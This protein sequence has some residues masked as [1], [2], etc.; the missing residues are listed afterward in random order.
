MTQSLDFRKMTKGTRSECRRFLLLALMLLLPMALMAQVESGRVVGTVFDTSGAVISGAAI[1]VKNIGTGVEHHT[2]TDNSGQFTVTQLQPGTY[3]VL[4][5]HEGFKGAE[6]AAFALDV[7]QVIQV[8][9]KLVVGAA[10]QTVEVASVEP[11]IETQTSSL[12]AVVEQ[13]AINDLPLNGRDFIQLT[14]LTPGVNSGPQGAVQGGG[15]PED[16]RGNGS[17]QA[18]GL[19]ATNNN[20]LLDGFDNNEQQIG[21]EI[22]QPPIDAIGEFKM[23]T[24]GFG[25]DIGKG[26]AVINVVLKSGTNKLHGDVYEFLRNSALDAKNYFDS[27]SKP[28]APFRQNQFGGTV[29]GPIRK[30]RT[31]FFVDYQGTRIGQSATSLSF[32]PPITVDPATGLTERDG[33]FSDLLTGTIDPQTGYDTGQIFDPLTYDAAT[34][35]RLPFDGNIIPTGKLD[36]AALN[37]VKLYPAPNVS[38]TVNEYLL[39]PI[40]VNN[41]DQVDVRVDHQL[42]RKDSTFATFDWGV[43]NAKHPDPFPG[44]AGGGSFSGNIQD[45][46]VAAGVSEVH[47]FADNKIDEFKIGYGRWAV[48]ATPFFFDEDLATQ[49]GIP[50]I[51][52]SPLGATG[53]MPN[54]AISE[55]GSLGDQD[56]FPELLRENNYQVLDTFTYLRGAHTFK[57]G[58][59][60][61]HRSHGMY[62]TQNPRGDLSFDQ[63]FTDAPQDSTGGNALASFLLGYPISANRD[64]L[65]GSYGMSWKEISAFAMDDYRVTQ[66][67]T[68]NMGV[69]YDVFTPEVEDHNRIA[70]FDFATGQFV[71]P[72]VSGASKSANVKTD[73]NN[74]APRIGFA[75]SPGQGKTVL[76]GGFGIFYDLQANQSD[77][78]LAYNPTGYFLSQTVT[79]TSV[80]PTMRLS[81]GFP[82]PVYA[83]LD[84]PFGRASAM[85]FNH[86]TTYIEEWNLN[87]EQAL[88]ENALLQVAYVGTHGVKLAALYNVNQPFQPLDS[89][90]SAAPNDGRPYYSTVPNISAIREDSNEQNLIAH[91]L[92]VRLEKRFSRNWSVLN[93]YTWQHTIGQNDEDESE[94]PQNT[95]NLKAERGDNGP[96]YRHQF[97]MAATY[98]LPFGKGQRFVNKNS[99]ADWVLGGWQIQGILGFN[100][101]QAFTPRMS[102]DPTNTGSAAPRPNIIGN[103]RDFSSLAGYS[104]TNPPTSNSFGTQYPGC[105]MANPHQNINCWYNPLAYALPA[106]ASGQQNAHLFGNAMRGTL[107]GPDSKNLD[108]SLF[109]NFTFAEAFKVQFRAE[110][111]NVTNTPNFALPSGTVDSAQAGII[112]ST[113]NAPRQIQFALKLMF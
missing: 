97:S 50:G 39:N 26:G 86:R 110:A 36:K 58:A 100:T 62:Q 87:L 113:S 8:Q 18:S 53:G 16:E 9:L 84:N 30:D 71:A 45:L 67:L 66:H 24:N 27:G 98:V 43:V 101:G 105:A 11:L 104:A 76:R 14:Y 6:Q 33:D 56:W 85:E 51:N 17:V 20:F 107:R 32:V 31:F 73:L 55:Y 91:A 37:V 99:V 59:D 13:Q 88:P 35:T 82:T 54:I 25:A 46:A 42:T 94:E 60:F 112:T 22:I 109:K 102:Y 5:Q 68:L 49:L 52:Q 106:L 80:Q 4:A 72:G 41:Q 79:N 34:N 10:S 89:N 29:G 63:Q 92:E 90:F 2:T 21:F 57:F 111:F 83:T 3:T 64:G 75:F 103:P 1:T 108:F 81:T 74:V 23:Q 95:H 38:G 69:R 19:T 48:Q 15:I 78:E 12:G 61:K 47:T 70:N 65:K 77:T 40:Y 28:I 96:D 93:S 44:K 7:N